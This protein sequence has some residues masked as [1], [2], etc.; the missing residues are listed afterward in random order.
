MK[1]DTNILGLMSSCAQYM[2]SSF[3]TIQP[4][5]EDHVFWMLDTGFGLS[6]REIYF[7]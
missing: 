4:L 6:Q 3:G 7:W 2:K 5:I 1:L